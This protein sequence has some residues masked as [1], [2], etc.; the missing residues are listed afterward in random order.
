MT[1]SDYLWDPDGNGIEVYTETP[2]DGSWFVSEREFGARTASGAVRSGRDPI[3]LD[4]LFGEL[5]P[6][7]RFD[8]PMPEGTKMGHVHLH[9]RDIDEAVHFYSDLIGFDVMGLS[10]GFGA[11]F[12]S[13]GGYHHHIGLNTWAGQG[14][15][16][17]PPGVAGLRHFTIELPSK[18]DL[19]EVVGRLEA[20]GVRPEESAEGFLVA[21][22]SGNRAH[23]A[24][25]SP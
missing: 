15:P 4:A 10:H 1:K 14:A 9:V 25:R 18:A 20:G 5:R 8:E 6:E 22:P 7:G 11:A 3:D 19:L 21:D 2:E 24:V 12:V 23:L 16:P 13:A 17:S